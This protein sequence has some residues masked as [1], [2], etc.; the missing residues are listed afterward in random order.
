MKYLDRICY[1]LLV[2]ASIF[3]IYTFFFMS[4][5]LAD[6]HSV[7]EVIP[8]MQE[9]LKEEDDGLMLLFLSPSCPYCLQS[10]PFYKVLTEERSQK[11]GVIVAV[12]T[13]ASLRLQK[14]LLQRDEVFVDTLIAL[15]AQEL[16]VHLVPTLVSLNNSAEVKRVWIG[17]LDEVG[18][19]EVLSAVARN[20][21]P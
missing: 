16:G 20:Q 13:S 10:Y 11:I 19:Q 9:Y 12:D 3:F 14:A 8:A 17:M 5:E 15:P 2:L 4:N 7:I 1:V 21:V 18:Q 6:D